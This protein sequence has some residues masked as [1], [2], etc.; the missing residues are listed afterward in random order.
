M[1]AVIALEDGS[2]FHGEGFGSIG[3]QVGEVVFNTSMT[4]YQESLTDPSYYRQIVVA[5]VPHVGNVGVNLDDPESERIWVAGYGVRALSPAI[6]N[7]RGWG[8]PPD[9][10]RSQNVVGISK[11]EEREL[12]RRVAT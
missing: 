8:S 9:F 2:L 11:L 4:G 12:V 6:S 1:R 10:L 7:W 5:T 3:L